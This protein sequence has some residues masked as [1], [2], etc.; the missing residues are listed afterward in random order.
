VLD[1]FEVG[2]R[3]LDILAQELR[4]LGR[5]RLLNIIAAYDLNSGGPDLQQFTEAQ[6]IT[7]IVVAVEARLLRR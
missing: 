4:A 1:P 6:L 5:A 2:S 7:L 3:S